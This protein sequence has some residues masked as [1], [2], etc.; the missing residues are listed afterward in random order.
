[1]KLRVMYSSKLVRKGYTAWVLFPFVF[2]RCSKEDCTDKLFR[3]EMEHVYQVM[4][5]GW[6]VFYIKY[7][8]RLIK[9]GYMDNPYEV[10]ARSR[11]NRP[12]TITERLFKTGSSDH[13]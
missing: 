6:W 1:M 12:L 3:H 7:I 9:Y 11:Q 8:Y 13:D 10:E 4:R 2:F 5:D